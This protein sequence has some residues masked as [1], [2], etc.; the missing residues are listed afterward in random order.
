MFWADRLEKH[1][2]EAQV[3][4]VAELLETNDHSVVPIGGLRAV[5][6]K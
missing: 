1:A 3:G 2:C 6:S 5:G 4:R